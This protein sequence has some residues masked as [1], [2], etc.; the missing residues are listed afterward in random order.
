MKVGDLVKVISSH[1]HVYGRTF[2]DVGIIVTLHPG[3][4]PFGRG[5]AWIMWAGQ[6]RPRLFGRVDYLEI[7]S[8]GG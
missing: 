8:E 1:E 6:Q 3:D 7:V 5:G 4:D 2:K